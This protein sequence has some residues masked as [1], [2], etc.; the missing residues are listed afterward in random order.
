M[1]PRSGQF[2]ESMAYNSSQGVGSA[3]VAWA[4]WG[5]GA[6]NEHGEAICCR[7]DVSFQRGL[8]KAPRDHSAINLCMTLLQAGA[9][10][11]CP[12]TG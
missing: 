1:E 7:E 2:A 3:S 11:L 5:Q 10:Q 8:S 12:G 6:E 9:R 4:G